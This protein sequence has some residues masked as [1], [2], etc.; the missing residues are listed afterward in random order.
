MS[1][2]KTK[3]EN[4]T[5]EFIR[6]AFLMYTEEKNRW[7]YIRKFGVETARKLKIKKDSDIE[8]LVDSLRK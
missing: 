8:R 2:R 7:Q 4:K 1:K 5:A 3:K 6:S